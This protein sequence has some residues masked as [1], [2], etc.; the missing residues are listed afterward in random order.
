M[1]RVYKWMAGLDQLIK[2]NPNFTPV[3]RYGETVEL[4]HQEES[5]IHDAAIRVLKA[6]QGLGLR[7]DNLAGVLDDLAHMTYLTPAEIHAGVVRQPTVAELNSI[8]ATH[9]LTGDTATLKVLTDIQSMFSRFLDVVQQNAIQQAGRII[10]DPGRLAAK[11]VEIQASIANMRNRPYFPLM[12]FGRHFVL[13][14][15]S[16]G[17]LKSFETFE[18]RWGIISA[19][20]RQQSAYKAAQARALPGEEVKFG[21]LP[22]NMEPFAGLPPA[23]LDVIK[24]ELTLTPLQIEALEG[25]QLRYSPAL[26]FKRLQKSN[27]TP[28]YSM[29]FRRAFARYFF[30][31]GKYHARTKFGWRLKGYVEAA[32]NTPN[33]NKAHMIADYMRDHMKNTVLDATGD[34]GWF[35]GRYLRLGTWVFRVFGGAESCPD[36]DDYLSGPGG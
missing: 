34:H 29:D 21:L 27:F 4:G 15:D 6:W 3:L 30:H 33:D 13:V 12:R 24:T 14:K 26:S 7:G 2:A 1:N 25:L 16:A 19:E 9:S 17:R 28:G 18:R 23:M 5:S 10:S 20:R 31:G 35:K 8:I 36:A 11:I 32:Q 22:E